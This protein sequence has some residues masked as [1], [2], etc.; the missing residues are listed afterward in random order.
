MLGSLDPTVQAPFSLRVGFAGSPSSSGVIVRVETP[1]LGGQPTEELFES[2]TP[3]GSH[4]GVLLFRSGPWLLGH[5]HEPFVP[6]EIATRTESLYR[7]VLSASRG[8]HLYR[9]WNYVPDINAEFRGL[10]NYR[11]FC[12]GRSLAFERVLGGEFQPQL[13]AASAVGCDGKRIEL[14]FAAGEGPATHFEN[15]EQIPAYLYPAEHGPRSPSF[16]RATVVRY[17]QQT[18][19]FISGTSAIKGHETVAPGSLDDQL[20]CTLDN[21]RLIAK[22]SGA[23]EDLGSS[24]RVKRHFK[25]YLRNASAF[26]RARTRLEAALFRSGDVVTYLKADICRAALHVEIEATLVG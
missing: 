14:I 22:K 20:E 5:A 18:W 25:V 6:A 23:G 19:T 15:P 7:R 16:A 12:Q 21:L 9:I 26:R 11:A 13:P 24:A 3:I 8:R 1:W 2:V 10:E 17:G 4:Q